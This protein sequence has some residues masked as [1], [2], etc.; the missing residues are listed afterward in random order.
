MQDVFHMIP[1]S[2]RATTWMAIILLIPLVLAVVLPWLLLG[3]RKA[4]FSLSP[5]GLRIAAHLYG[6]RI[7]ADALLLNQ[8]RVVDLDQEPA[9]QPKRRTNGIGLPGYQAGWFRLR[10][11]E[12]A[13][14]FLPDRSRVVYLPTTKGYA[15]LMSLDRPDDFLRSL[16]EMVP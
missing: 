13:L 16:R 15:V 12:K 2:G 3:A 4:D 1:P 6:R 10:D 5:E 7:P 9:F 14:L 11:G 8:A